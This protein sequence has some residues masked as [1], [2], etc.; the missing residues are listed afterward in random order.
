[1]TQATVHLVRHGEVHNPEG[2]LYGRIPGFRL[3]A[4]GRQMAQQ[5]ADHFRARADAGARI[6]YLAASPLERAQETAQ[7]IA[8]AL[9]LD[10]ETEPRIVEAENRFEGLSVTKHQLRN[11]R[12]WP[13][14]IN[15]LTPSWGEPYAG[16]V[17]RM[18]QAVDHAREQA[19]AL[20]AG[21]SPVEAILVSHQLP[22]WVTR[23]AAEG[24]RLWHDPRN[25]EC[26]LTSVTSLIFNEGRLARVDYA[27]PCADLL[28]GATN[29]PGA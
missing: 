27:E 2:V 20:G 29:I 15:P 12:Y 8:R 14:L 1:M 28:P 26:T 5:V 9:G 24:R 21:D 11:P 3:S 7:P 19:V 16:Q 4:L 13:L 6:V 25:R 18:M 22:V 17:V 10:I 23:L